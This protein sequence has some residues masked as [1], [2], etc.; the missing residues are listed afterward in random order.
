MEMLIFSIVML[1]LIAGFG[2]VIYKIA[3]PKKKNDNT[4]HLNS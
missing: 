2:F 1:H 3:V 4:N